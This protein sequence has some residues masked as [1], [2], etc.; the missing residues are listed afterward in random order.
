[1][2]RS[3]CRG[4]RPQRACAGERTG[5]ISICLGI[6]ADETQSTHALAGRSIQ[7][8]PPPA[9][10]SPWSTD[11]ACCRLSPHGFFSNGTARSQTDRAPHDRYRARGCLRS[12]PG[13]QR[14]CDARSDPVFTHDSPSLAPHQA[15]HPLNPQPRT[16]LLRPGKTCALRAAVLPPARSDVTATRQSCPRHRVREFVCAC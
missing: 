9:D 4:S 10:S 13:A 3:I 11:L 14:R 5:R 8:R 12:E 1:M 15:I 6:R 2:T 7:P 16:P